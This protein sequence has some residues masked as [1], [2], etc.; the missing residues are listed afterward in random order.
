[1]DTAR[2]KA[3]VSWN[4]CNS[5]ISGKIR[6]SNQSGYSYFLTFIDD[7]LRFTTVYLIKEKSEIVKFFKEFKEMMENKFERKIAALRSDNGTEYRNLQMVHF[8]K[9]NGIRMEFTVPHSPQQNGVAERLNRTI[10][11]M[12]K[13]LLIG[14]RLPTRFWP[15]AIQAAVHI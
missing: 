2:S 4:L 1:M 12:A 10:D 8:C 5:D 3:F 11:D 15:E 7:F 13:S 6:I 14:A 9:E